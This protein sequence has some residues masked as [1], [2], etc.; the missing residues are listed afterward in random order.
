MSLNFDSKP[1]FYK[2]NFSIEKGDRLCLVGR[3]GSGKSTL[4]KILAGL[5][6]PE[7]GERF[8]KPGCNISLLRQ[9]FDFS[10][11][12]T[13]GDY[14]LHGL[15]EV[16]YLKQESNFS[17]FT[18]DFN[19]RFAIASGGEV[20]RAC[21]IRSFI[22]PSD[23]LLLDEPTNHLDIES[24][25]FLQKY[26]LGT[27]KAFVLISHDRVL[28]EQVGDQLLW[29]DRGLV[30]KINKNFKYFE[31]FRDKTYELELE[32][33]QKL[34]NKIKKESRWAVEGISGRR[35]RNQKRLT[36]LQK[37][38][39]QQVSARIPSGIPKFKFSDSRQ[40]GKL[41][42]EAKKITKSYND[43][44]IIKELSFSIC[45]GD[46]IA[47]L[48]PNGVGKTTLVN[49]FLKKVEPTSGNVRLGTLLKI[50]TFEQNKE[51]LPTDI[52]LWDFFSGVNELGASGKSD[53]IVVQNQS[54]HILGYL[55]DFLF[56]TE[57]IYGRIKDLSGGEK[58]RLLLAMLM[59]KPSNLLVLDEP[60]N[61]LD[62]ETL[63]LLKEKLHLYSGTVIF[64]SHDRNFIESIATHTII[65][66]KQKQIFIHH[67]GFSDYSK[68]N[69]KKN[70][71]EEANKK[72]KISRKKIKKISSKNDVSINEKKLKSLELEIEKLT[73]QI[74]KLELAL[75]DGNLFVENRK[76]FDFLSSELISRQKSLA[77]AEQEWVEF[78]SLTMID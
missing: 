43:F 46:R 47:I 62:L 26:L 16:D 53:H 24:I 38:K 61:D 22:L 8:I 21:L 17:N 73:S 4:L 41:V 13:L 27:R 11:F 51:S 30:Q 45:N 2:V 70:Y 58:A 65:L 29:L 19:K 14:I 9:S 74:A 49:L 67:G 59:A 60:T 64:V 3:N 10:H 77:E 68:S 76:K 33:S 1:L 23:V 54:R 69:A 28:L 34:K 75:S 44:E 66:D 6:N 31:D 32:A 40:S 39:S 18:V 48:G 7:T 5:L 37:L 78:G 25:E 50:A 36:E 20:R 71:V 63:D 57:Q 42:V 52:S 72:N 35:K 55:Q 56:T 12:N 15:N